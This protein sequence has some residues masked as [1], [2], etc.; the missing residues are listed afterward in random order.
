[1]LLLTP[2]FN[3]AY[4]KVADSYN[5]FLAA[6]AAFELEFEPIMDAINESIDVQDREYTPEEKQ[7][8]DK[9]YRYTYL[10]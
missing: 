5:A 2:E 3:L 7:F 4:Q 10:D 6:R 9:L 1:M 8:S